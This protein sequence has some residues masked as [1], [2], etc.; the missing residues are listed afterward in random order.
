MGGSAVIRSGGGIALGGGLDGLNIAGKNIVETNS[1]GGV[2]EGVAVSVALSVAVGE[3]VPVAVAVASGVFEA[4]A[5][6]WAAK[7]PGSL[8]CARS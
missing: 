4:V 8:V 3:I 2:A 7:R 6:G 1:K 5:I